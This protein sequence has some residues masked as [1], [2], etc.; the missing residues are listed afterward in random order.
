M[1]KYARRF[2]AVP[3]RTS[4]QTWRAIVDCLGPPL[5]DRTVLDAATNALA[6]IIAEEVPATKPI[7]L[8][9]CGPRVSIYTVYGQDSIDGHNVNERPVVGLTFNPG[10]KLHV[11]AG[12]D[13]ELISGLVDGSH[14]VVGPPVSNATSAGQGLPRVSNFDL[15]ALE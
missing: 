11:P 4:T 10:W 14:V 12:S 15:T 6:I 2:A 13:I 7:V 1:T 3:A 5:A 8:T 9:G